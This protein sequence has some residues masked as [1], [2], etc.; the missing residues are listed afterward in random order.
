M[1][2]SHWVGPMAAEWGSM[3]LVKTASC[4]RLLSVAVA[5][6]FAELRS[7]LVARCAQRRT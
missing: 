3:L 5:S 2:S 4:A 7:N 6:L 1:S